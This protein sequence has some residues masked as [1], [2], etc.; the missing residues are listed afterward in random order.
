MSLLSKSLLKAAETGNESELLQL[1]ELGV[2]FASDHMDT[3]ALHFACKNGHFNTAKT[4]IRSG[5]NVNLK[6]KVEKTALHFAA[7][8]GHRDVVE[9]LLRFGADINAKD[10]LL[11]TPLHWAVTEQHIAVVKLL[12]ENNA[13]SDEK[14]R[15]EKTAL[16]IAKE[17][18][19]FHILDQL[20]QSTEPQIDVESHH[21][22]H[23][24]LPS[25][26]S[27]SI[28][29]LAT[30]AVLNS[31]T[32]PWLYG[33]DNNGV[34]SGASVSIEGANTITLTEAGKKALQSWSTVNE[35]KNDKM[36]SITLPN[37]LLSSVTEK[38]I[39]DDDEGDDEDDD[40]GLLLPIQPNKRKLPHQVDH[41]Q[42]VQKRQRHFIENSF[43]EQLIV[44]EKD[45][46]RSLEIA[47]SEIEEYKRKLVLKQHE[48]EMYKKTLEILQESRLA[49]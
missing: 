49:T 31:D 4:L 2:P 23:D 41:E 35:D 25:V 19:D 33:S 40:V 22:D 24:D 17:T 21:L 34:P 27:P 11:M 6:T 29:T 7:Q 45:L 14:N 44:D 43:G 47:Q 3:S 15:F 42:D 28:D 37:R 32:L 20:T 16:D 30:L 38:V 18:S 48:A 5:M 12:L 26:S 8:N 36:I 9:L 1:V 39:V 10:L 46:Q 13:L